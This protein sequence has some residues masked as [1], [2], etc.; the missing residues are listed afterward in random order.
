MPVKYGDL[1]KTLKTLVMT[2]KK[3]LSNSERKFLVSLKEGNP[4]WSLLAVLNIERLPAIQ[5]KLKNIQK[6]DKKKHAFALS[7]LKRKLEL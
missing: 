4:D 6:M 2:L 1:Q 7:E 5:W 3:R